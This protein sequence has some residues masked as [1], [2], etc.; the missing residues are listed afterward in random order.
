MI[1][2]TANE[3]PYFSFLLADLHAH[4]MATPFA[5]VAVA[6]ALQLALRGPPAW[7]GRRARRARRACARLARPRCRSTR[8]TSSTTRRRPCSASCAL[9][10]WASPSSDRVAWRRAAVWAL[11]WLG[12]LAPASSC[13]S[14]STTRPR[15]AASESSATTTTSRGSRRDVLLIY[16][17]PLWILLAVAVTRLSVPRRGTSSGAASRR[18]FVLVLLAPARLAGLLLLLV[19]VACSLFIALR[20]RSTAAERVLLAARRPSGLGLIAVGEIVYIR[21]RLHRT[22]RAIGSTPS[23]RPATRHGSCLRSPRAWRS[24]PCDGGFPGLRASPGRRGSSCSSRSPLLYPVA[25]SYSRSTGFSQPPTLDGDALAERAPD[26][27]AAIRWLRANVDGHADDPRGRSGPT[28]T[29]KA[30]RGYRPSPA[31]PP[32]SAGRG[33]RSSGATTRNSGG[34]RRAHLRD[35]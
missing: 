33:T 21:G 7:R 19:L 31:F 16:G 18:M 20:S 2:G 25:A 35:P 24:S 28:T 15:R 26:D 32:S 9:L 17:L 29:R 23:S 34:R 1:D 6:Y 14:T 12:A 27:A 4:V 22:R 10:I 3:F 30:M 8:S 13:R 5:L 11:A